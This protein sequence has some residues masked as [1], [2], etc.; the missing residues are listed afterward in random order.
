MNFY[1]S[2]FHSILGCSAF[3]PDFRY[4]W[5]GRI[6]AGQPCACRAL[7]C[8]SASDSFGGIIKGCSRFF[9]CSKTTQSPLDAIYSNSC[10]PAGIGDFV[11]PFIARRIIP[12]RF[13][14]VRVLCL[15]AISQLGFP[16]VKRVVVDMVALHIGGGFHN[17]PR[18]QDC[19]VIGMVV[20]DG[21]IRL[22]VLC[23]SCAP[24]PLRQPFVIFVIYFCNLT[25]RKRYLFHGYFFSMTI[26]PAN[27][28]CFSYSD[29]LPY[30]ATMALRVS[31]RFPQ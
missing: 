27:I 4:S 9:C 29:P 17:L 2:F 14:V 11:N 24:L 13:S 5:I 23:P 3:M 18:H 1:S 6:F 30:F 28:T 19:A 31:V 12:V 7:V 22:C 16:V 21:I 10:A 8:I 25:L 15:G 20:S 26:F